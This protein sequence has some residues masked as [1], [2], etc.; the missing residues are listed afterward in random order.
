MNYLVKNQ[1]THYGNLPYFGTSER[2]WCCKKNI[3][4]LFPEQRACRE[5]ESLISVIEKKNN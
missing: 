3:S 1:R 5:K 4:E 2:A